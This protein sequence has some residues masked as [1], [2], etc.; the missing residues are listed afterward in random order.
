MKELPNKSCDF[1]KEKLDDNSSSMTKLMFSIGKNSNEVEKKEHFVK[2]GKNSKIET[3]SKSFL[4]TSEPNQNFVA[5]LIQRFCHDVNEPL[6]TIALYNSEAS[7]HTLGHSHIFYNKQID[8]E[9]ERLK[10]MFLNFQQLVEIGKRDNKDYVS[11]KD[12]YLLAINDLYPYIIL[13]KAIVTLENNLPPL[14]TYEVSLNE[15]ISVFSN[16]ISNAIKYAPSD[17]IACVRVILNDC[18]SYIEVAIIDGN[19]HIDDNI[20]DNICEPFVR[21]K[22]DNQIEGTGLGLTIVTKILSK[23]GSHLTYRRQQKRGNCFSFR[24]LKQTKI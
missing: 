20:L 7:K 24:L 3:K 9:V 5:D 11:I 21:G 15:A 17:G 13:K 8:F 16:L 6:R 4:A 12:A 23:W 10:K 14:D 18:G 2:N 1:S 19:E 22:R